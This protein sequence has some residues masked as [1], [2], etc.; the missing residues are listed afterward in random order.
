MPKKTPTDPELA[1]LGRCMTSVD[2]LPEAARSRI[3]AYLVD[4]YMGRDLAA[5]LWRAAERAPR[6][7]P[8][9]QQ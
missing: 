7:E 8:G 6:P 3:L 4:K 5:P 1:A 2:E 9:P